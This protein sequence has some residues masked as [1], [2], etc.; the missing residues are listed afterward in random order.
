MPGRV[1]RVNPIVGLADPAFRDNPLSV[2]DPAFAGALMQVELPPFEP[3]TRPICLGCE[4]TDIAGWGNDRF[5]I[6]PST[7]PPDGNPVRRD[8]P[9]FLE[10]MAWFYANHAIDRLEGLGYDVPFERPVAIHAH[11]ET[12]TLTCVD[13]C[14]P[15]PVINDDANCCNRGITLYYRALSPNGQGGTGSA[16]EDAEV[17]VHE[18][19]HYLHVQFSP[20][21]AAKAELYGEFAEGTADL[22]AALL[23]DDL[24]N[25][26]SDGCQGEWIITYYAPAF[27]FDVDGY[28][29]TRALDNDFVWP[30]D[31]FGRIHHDGMFWSG[32][33]WR[34]REALGTNV[35]LRLL[36]ESIQVLPE[37]LSSFEQLA[38][39]VLQAD[40]SLYGGHHEDLVR[41]AFAKH[42]IAAPPLADVLGNAPPPA[43]SVD[44][45]SFLAPTDAP[46]APATKDTPAVFPGLLAIA[47]VLLATRRS[48]H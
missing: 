37:D 48:R 13:V 34:I 10:Q 3:V 9:R 19:G 42:G 41:S 6:V 4:T 27:S 12:Q 32:P 8:D 14:V 46:V 21:T 38:R 40:A 30:Q 31:E 5:L 47:L 22:F 23:L 45:P 2:D 18:L 25:G 26:V 11:K 33:M 29:C 36:M 43:P 24:S 15:G 7:S 39:A 1:F 16:A 28:A 20:V 44:D 35:T 17:I